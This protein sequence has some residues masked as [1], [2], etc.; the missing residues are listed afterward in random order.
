MDKPDLIAEAAKI[1]FSFALFRGILHQLVGN[2]AAPTNSIK[3]PHFNM[4]LTP[5]MD[6]AA[7]WNLT[8]ILTALI[9]VLTSCMVLQSY[10]Y[11]RHTYQLFNRLGIP[12]PKPNIIKGNGDL[13]RNPSLLSIE[14]MDQW[15]A[16]YGDIY[17]YFIGQKP[18]IVI[19]DLDLVQQV[20]ISDFHKFVNRP[21]MSIEIRPVIHSMVGLRDQRWKEVRRVISP[22]FSRRKLR[23]ISHSI[24]RCVDVLVEVVGKNGI[25]DAGMNFYDA[26]QGLTCQVIG[27]CALDTVIDCQR[28]PDDAFLN[29]LRK[30]LQAGNHPII[31]LAIYFPVVRKI[32]AVICRIASPTGQF[33]QS[34]IDNV[35]KV[36]DQRR[37]DGTSHNDILQLLLD[38]AENKIDNSESDSS[39]SSEVN[40]LR[41]GPRRPQYLLSDDEIIANAWVFLL[42][43]FETTANAL[44]YCSYLLATHP[45]IQDKLQQEIVENI[46]QD[47]SSEDLTDEEYDIIGH[48]PYLD[49]VLCESLRLFPPVVLFVN[50]EAGED[51]QLGKYHIPAGT[52]VQ[53]PVWQIHHDRNLWPDPYRF[54]P[55]RFDSELKKSHHPMA[56]I[57][58]G[59]GP[60]GCLGIRFA[61]VEAKIALVKLLQKYRLVPC[62]RTETKLTLTAPTVTLNPKNGVWLRAEVREAPD[63]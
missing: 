36:I 4:T 51:T 41:G 2:P 23:R 57:P 53:I 21:G 61:M 20:L 39:L 24:Q 22:T 38:A 9:I 54:D 59:T 3:S 37:E 35:Q 46:A 47:R 58:F 14:V 7:D 18:Y 49:Q 13:M 17:G 55:D 6:T 26:F 40:E 28:K 12:G 60:R 42:G 25:T 50:R 8:N 1:V 27:E 11:R 33:T 32:L 10:W 16:E 44:T 43:G 62:E 45:E 56:W 52:N 5:A 19:S 15:Q 34:I 31:D 63:V 30:F 29:S 48:M